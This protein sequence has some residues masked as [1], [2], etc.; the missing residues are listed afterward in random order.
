MHPVTS[1]SKKIIAASVVFVSVLAMLFSYNLVEYLN[2]T[3]LP[4]SACTGESWCITIYG[5]IQDNAYIGMS[6]L[7]DGRNFT[8]INNVDVNFNNSWGTEYHRTYSGVALDEI[9]TLIDVQS[10][11]ALYIK[12]E[13]IDG[14]S[15][16]MLPISVVLSNP[17][18]VLLAHKENNQLL[19]PQEQGGDGPIKS[20]MPREIIENNTEVKAIFAANGQAT[21]YNSNYAVK[22]CSAIQVI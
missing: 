19:L 14:Y 15:S 2:R 16:L 22:Y 4:P 10:M 5:N 17:G 20:I 8:Y 18:K 3:R 9:L 1:K 13:A 12:F 21:V 7:Q 11:G 6:M